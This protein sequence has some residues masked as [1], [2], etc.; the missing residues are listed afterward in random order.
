MRNVAKLYLPDATRYSDMLNTKELEE[1]KKI[2]KDLN[3]E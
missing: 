1:L 2:K 3:N